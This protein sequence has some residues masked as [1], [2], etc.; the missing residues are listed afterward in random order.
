MTSASLHVSGYH[1][2]RGQ[3]RVAGW[4]EHHQTY[5]VKRAGSDNAGENHLLRR[6]FAPA[7]VLALREISQNMVSAVAHHGIKLSRFS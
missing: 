6:A 7:A 1:V 5:V 2:T 3:W 4:K